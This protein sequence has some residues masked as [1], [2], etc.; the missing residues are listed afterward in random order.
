MD[1]DDEAEPDARPRTAA[2][3]ITVSAKIWPAPLPCVARE[4]DEGE[5]ARRS[6]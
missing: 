5:V 6:A 4:R 3:A 2:T 1:R